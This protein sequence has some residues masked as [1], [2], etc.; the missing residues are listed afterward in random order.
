MGKKIKWILAIAFFPIVI[1]YVFLKHIYNY[2][3]K[4]YTRS[5]L[6]SLDVSQ[7]DTLDGWEFE[8]LIEQI[9]LVMGFKITHTPKTK[10]YGADLIISYKKIPFGFT[11][12]HLFFI[13]PRHRYKS[14]K[15]RL[16][17]TSTFFLFRTYFAA[18]TPYFN[19]FQVKSQ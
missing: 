6:S 8:E 14:K 19:L 9:F 7:I 13:L 4:L 11:K 17:S 10:D 5:Y 2:L 12:S 16:D 1:F 3:K 15:I 18:F